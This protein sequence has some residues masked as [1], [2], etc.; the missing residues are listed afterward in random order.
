MENKGENKLSNIV[1]IGIIL[2][3]SSI[4][5]L[6]VIIFGFLKEQETKR[7]ENEYIKVELVATEQGE[8]VYIVEDEE[9]EVVY[10]G[11]KNIE[12]NDFKYIDDTHLYI[13]L[14]IP[15][16][17]LEYIGIVKVYKYGFDYYIKLS[18]IKTYLNKITLIRE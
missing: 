18:S 13:I 12:I 10:D 7:L 4:L 9:Y 6:L 17:N 2:L 8:Y 15:V 3:L 5:L 16:D 1:S 14:K 11:Y